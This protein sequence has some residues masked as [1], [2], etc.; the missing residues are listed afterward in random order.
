MT[1]ASPAAD[2]SS[3]P[4]A[5]KPL[6]TGPPAS[7]APSLTKRQADFAEATQLAKA[8]ASISRISRLLGVDRKTLRHWLRAGAVP[9]WRQ[10]RR[11]RMID[12]HL[13]HLEKRWAEGCRNATLLWRELTT[14]GFQKRYTAVKTWT[15]QRRGAKAA[16]GDE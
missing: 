13:A 14:L 2:V 3:E 15:A 1:V 16:A 8:G 4:G 9:S 5:V 7:G 12:T 6:V 10:P 11:G